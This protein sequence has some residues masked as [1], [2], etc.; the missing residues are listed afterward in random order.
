MN[1]KEMFKIVICKIHYS[2]VFDKEF[3]NVVSNWQY[4]GEFQKKKMLAKELLKFHQFLPSKFITNSENLYRRIDL[5][6]KHALLIGMKME[7]H[8]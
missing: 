2:F 4:E 8:L 1:I 6:G 3:L 7:S 5:D